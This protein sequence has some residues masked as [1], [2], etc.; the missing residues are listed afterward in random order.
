MA[1]RATRKVLRESNGRWQKGHSGNPTGKNAG[2]FAFQQL[3]RDNS[4]EALNKLIDIMR[5]GC[6]RDA[7]RAAEI[8]IERGY[9]K[10]QQHINITDEVDG[11]SDEALLTEAARI[12]IDNQD[13]LGE[14]DMN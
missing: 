7:L 1:K 11:M 13:L 5:T 6:D 10:A 4:E 9:G 3:A 8:I 12:L 2:Y 14:T